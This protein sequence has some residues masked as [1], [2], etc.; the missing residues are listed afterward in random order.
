MDSLIAQY[1]I[2]AAVFIAAVWHLA[3]RL[4]PSKRPSKGCAKGCGCEGVA[5]D[6]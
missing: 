5:D 2:I 3:K 4:L 1:I 6:K